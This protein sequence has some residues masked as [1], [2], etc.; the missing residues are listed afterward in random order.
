MPITGYDVSKSGCCPSSEEGFFCFKESGLTPS[1][2]IRGSSNSRRKSI[3]AQVKNKGLCS[4]VLTYLKMKGN[5]RKSSWCKIKISS[6][7]A[8]P[9]NCSAP[10]NY[11]KRDCSHQASSQTALKSSRLS[12]LRLKS[13]STVGFLREVKD[14]KWLASCWLSLELNTGRLLCKY[15]DED[16]GPGPFFYTRLI[17]ISEL[18][19]SPMQ[20]G[21]GPLVIEDPPPGMSCLFMVISSHGEVRSRPWLPLRLR[22]L[23]AVSWVML[24]VNCYGSDHFYA[25]YACLKMVLC[26]STVTTKLPHKSQTIQ[27]S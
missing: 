13:Y 16:T 11:K 5:N 23:S 17:I 20:T 4:S 21:P 14:P 26:P 10:L 9:T 8:W 24:R 3:L 19:D 25:N 18:K 15:C 1:T 27:S 12:S 6:P 7:W 22:R 2:R